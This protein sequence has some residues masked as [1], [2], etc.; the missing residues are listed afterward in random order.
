M[1]RPSIRRFTANP[2]P[3]SYVLQR[4]K[5][6]MQRRELMHGGTT[7]L[8]SAQRRKCPLMRGTLRGAGVCR[9]YH[10]DRFQCSSSFISVNNPLMFCHLRWQRSAVNQEHR[11][12]SF[13][14]TALT[15]TVSQPQRLLWHWW[16]TSLCMDT[17][18]KLVRYASGYFFF[19]WER[20]EA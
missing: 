11:S 10:Q 14:D 1:A 6:I 3:V 15:L 2:I 12:F 16:Y 17:N 4:I 18:I 9:V 20:S 7:A 8:L 19:P 5:L 13:F